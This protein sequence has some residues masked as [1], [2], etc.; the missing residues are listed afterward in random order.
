MH[1][2]LATI[3][4]T[5]ALTPPEALDSAEALLT[6][7][8]YEI[9][10]RTDTSVTGVRRKREGMFT[11]ALVDLTV[12]ALPQPQGGVQIKLQG[13]DRQGV[14]A[15]QAEWSRWNESLP[16]LGKGQQVREQPVQ[17]AS[18]P[19]TR[20]TRTEVT[21]QGATRR[22]RW[23]PST[24][25]NRSRKREMQKAMSGGTLR[26]HSQ[27]DGR[28]LLHGVK[29]HESQQAN[30]RQSQARLKRAQVAQT[31]FRVSMNK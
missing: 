22:K 12:E 4:Q 31:G 19:E 24:P 8:G 28:P 25:L 30:R 6:Q 14:Q 23:V 5:V 17:G 1:G 27:G 18:S 15:R 3:R 9:T 2:E 7:Q 16:K 10:E 29:N 21:F 13:N 26:Q 20:E 11:Y